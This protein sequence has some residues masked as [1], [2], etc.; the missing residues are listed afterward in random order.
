MKAQSPESAANW[1]PIEAPGLP[2]FG[3]SGIRVR[4]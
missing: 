3:G 4:V 1:E 2:D